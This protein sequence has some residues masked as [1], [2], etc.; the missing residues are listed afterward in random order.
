MEFKS[1]SKISRSQNIKLRGKNNTLVL[2]C[3]TVMNLNLRFLIPF[4]IA[5]KLEKKGVLTY[6]DWTLQIGRRTHV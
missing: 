5:T 2:T 6:D 3:I 4:K 1:F